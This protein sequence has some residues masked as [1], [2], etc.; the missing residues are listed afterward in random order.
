MSLGYFL[1]RH[2]KSALRQAVIDMAYK[3][4]YAYRVNGKN[5]VFCKRLEVSP[6]CG[7]QYFCPN[8]QM[9]ENTE[10]ARN[11]AI[12]QKTMIEPCK[13]AVTRKEKP[14]KKDATK[15]EQTTVTLAKNV[16]GECLEEIAK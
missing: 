4:P 14:E 5:T 12:A 2:I 7:H 1:R 16:K 13:V 15:E 8:T 6:Y 11:C 9:W 10:G 3:C